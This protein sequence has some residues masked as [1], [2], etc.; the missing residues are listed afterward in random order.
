VPVKTIEQADLAAAVEQAADGIVITDITGEIRFVNPA[1]TAMTGFTSQEVT[2]QHTRILKSGHQSAEF[3]EGL[4]NTIRNGQ[5]WHGE[6]VNRRKDGTLYTEEMRITP[7]RGKDGEIASYIAIKHDVTARR[8]ADEAKRLLAAIVESSED[9]IIAFTPAG[10]IHTW[11]RAAETMFG[12][13]AGEAIGK[14]GSMLLAPERQSF[15][16]PFIERVLQG[17]AI[18][19]HETLCIHKDGR[20]LPVSLTVSPVRNSAGEVVAISVTLRDVSERRD[21]EQTRALL[22]SIVES[23]EDAIVAWQ[24]DGTVISWNRGAEA[25][26]GY[27]SKDAIGKNVAVFTAPGR[28]HLPG[29]VMATILD[30]G[31]VAPYETVL[32]TVHASPIDVALS[33]SPVRNR[34][35]AIVAIAAIARDISQRLRTERALQDGERKFREVFEHAPVGVC[36]SGQNGYFTR[37]NMAFCRMLGYSEQEMLAIPWT[38]M[39]HPDDLELSFRMV[40]RLRAQPDTWVELEKRY[41]HKNGTAVWVRIRIS[42]VPNGADPSY[43]VIHAEDITE[44]RKA[45]HALSESEDRFRVM[46]DSCPTM[47]WVTNATGGNSFINRAYREFFGVAAEQA[48]GCKWHLLIHPDDALAYVAEFQR[49]V[50][51]HSLFRAEARVRRAD[52]EWRLLGSNAEPRLSADGEYLGHIGLS[53]DITERRNAE[54][55]LRSSEEK[56]RQLA[57][58]IRE[59][60]WMMNPLATEI[61]YVSPAYEQVWGRTCASLYQNPMAWAEAIHPDDLER[62]HKLFAR[63]LQG[64]ALDSEYRITAPEGGEKWIRDRAFPVRDDDGEI[65]RIVGIAEEITERRRYESELIQARE[66][67]DAAS[68][69]KSRFLANMSHEIRTPMNGVL[70][71]V[72]L[73]LETE[74]TEEQRHFARVAQDSGR[75]LLSLIDDILD[76]SKIESGKIV[77]ERRS[78]DLR[79]T[80]DAVVRLFRV[81][82]GAKKLETELRIAPQVPATVTGDSHRL[83]Q[84]LTN[85]TANAVKFTD[86]GT[87]KLEATLEGQTG[88]AVTIRFSVTDTGI[89]IRPDQAAKLF[90]PFVQ[91]DASTTR[92]YGGTGLGLAIS[93]ELAGMMGGTIGVESREGEGSTFWFTAVFEPGQACAPADSAPAVAVTSGHTARI[94]V[95]EDNAVNR[96]VVLAQLQKLGYDAT[97]VNDGQA[98]VEAIRQGTCDLVLMDCQMPV[99]D[100]FEATRQIRRSL[101]SGI[102]IIALT[103]NAMS[104]DRD[105]CLSEGMNDYLAKPLDLH[106]LADVLGKWGGAPAGPPVFNGDAL[107]GRLM[108][109]RQLAGLILRGF[110]L[111]APSQLE[112]LRSLLDESDAAG[113][114]LQA[115]SLKGAAA[116]VGAEELQASAYALETA[117]RGGQLDGCGELLRR[118]AAHFGRFVSTIEKNG[119]TADATDISL[120]EVK[121]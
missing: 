74:L 45:Q 14:P 49:A 115:H 73:L 113:V 43:F 19:Q 101:H 55:A 15:L 87:I 119:W 51:E 107:L 110:L 76:L 9:A 16:S 26:L 82:A 37:V 8:A 99:M 96:T 109:D 68:L 22:A 42:L 11:N 67:A 120:G 98:A 80:M 54:L 104:A 25:L 6:M 52:G 17:N 69:A 121:R 89:G 105:Q 103:A 10:I 94:L 77:L 85:L 60:F 28:E 75:S 106:R 65:I 23:S 97:A 62:A 61:L 71:M 81:Q 118:A 30:G 31:S 83:R 59:V 40:E 13:A 20:L 36:V 100:G 91:A 84:V 4:W 95:A 44:R 53:S 63:Q 2:G 48:E 32:H 112:K 78:F 18:P 38:Q 1:F 70:G 79:D 33:V 116:T 46:A 66:G 92:K 64:E 90:S 72:Q 93:R 29:Q 39:T 58:N 86:R 50:R 24:P 114:R 35:G 34:A 102:P 21:A 7:V 12:Y 47:L 111:D 117:A 3:Y 57:E 27:Q 5:I 56:F 88:A 41:I 108:G